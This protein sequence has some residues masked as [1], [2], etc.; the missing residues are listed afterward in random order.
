MARV[1]FLSLR[2]LSLTVRIFNPILKSIST[3]GEWQ[4]YTC[5]DPLE[6]ANPANVI[7]LEKTPKD[8]YEL[9][10]KLLSYEQRLKN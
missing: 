3:G 2:F 7:Y 6:L 1:N 10:L 4:N 9:G 5:Y 8:T